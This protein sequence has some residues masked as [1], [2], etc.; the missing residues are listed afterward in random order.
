MERQESG[1]KGHQNWRF[2]VDKKEELGKPRE[3][4]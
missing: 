2:G 1:L 3:T 4:L